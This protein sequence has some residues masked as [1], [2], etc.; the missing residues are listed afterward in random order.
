MLLT[1][2]IRCPL[3]GALGLAIIGVALGSGSALAIDCS[4]ESEGVDLAV[5]AVRYWVSDEGMPMISYAIRN[6]GKSPS[7]SFDVTLVVNGVDTAV[8][9]DHARG[10]APGRVWRWAFRLNSW[11]PTTDGLDLGVRV[12]TAVSIGPVADSYVD[13]CPDNDQHVIRVVRSQPP[14]D[15]TPARRLPGD[16]GRATGASRDRPLNAYAPTVADALHGRT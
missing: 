14:T 5:Q 8:H 15:Q 11:E 7:T 13:H 12:K 3:A 1:R 4:G 2:G 16:L 6:Q 10:L 9:Q